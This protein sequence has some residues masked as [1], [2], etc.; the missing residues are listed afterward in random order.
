MDENRD[1]LI[2]ITTQMYSLS[3][4]LLDLNRPDEAEKLYQLANQLYDVTAELKNK[5]K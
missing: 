4:K 3:S 5:T 1:H 2:V